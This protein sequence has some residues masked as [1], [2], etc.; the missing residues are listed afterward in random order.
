MYPKNFSNQ[1][2]QSILPG[3]GSIPLVATDLM[4]FGDEVST[5][6]RA[7][8]ALHRDAAGEVT[9]K[10]IIYGGPRHGYGFTPGGRKGLFRST[11]NGTCRPRLVLVDGPIQAIC[12]AALD[13]PALAA[14]TTYAAPSGPWTRA[15]GVALEALLNDAAPALVRLAFAP[16][17]DGSSPSA[18]AC[19]A[20]LSA[21]PAVMV[22]T[23][24]PP[25][26]GWVEALRIQRR[27]SL[28][29]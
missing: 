1:A 2:S 27:A 4:S 23:L 14:C 6:G 22:E 16:G 28:A 11:G 8:R 9:G 21:I 25:A 17:R 24:Q 5:G 26:G 18:D 7:L 29:A 13:G 20:L 3:F 12:C 19:R 10:E 15:A